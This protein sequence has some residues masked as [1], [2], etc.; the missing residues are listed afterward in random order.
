MIKQLQTYAGGAFGFAFAVVWATL[1]L[2][3]AGACLFAA[4]VGAGFVLYVQRRPQLDVSR[5]VEQVRTR[6]RS[7]AAS[8]SKPAAPKLRANTRTG[9][10][11]VGGYPVTKHVQETTYGWK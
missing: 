1:G 9:E 4:G 6:A 2:R 11:R 7:L 5:H 3:T 8:A 10:R